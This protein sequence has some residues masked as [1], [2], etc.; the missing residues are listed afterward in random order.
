MKHCGTIPLETGRLIL[1]RFTPED[2]EAMFENWAGDPQ[3]TRYLTWSAHQSPKQTLSVLTRWLRQYRRADFYEWA[4][5]EKSS[6]ALIGSIGLA[7]VPG[8]R[9]SAEAGYS[10]GQRW[11]N[12]G[13]ATEALREVLDFAVHRVGYKRIIA[14]HAIENPASGRVMQK[15]GMS[16]CI[17]AI[18]SV[19]TE[20][21]IFDCYLYEF[22]S[23]ARHH[24]FW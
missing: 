14:K 1:R 7:G 16:L 13:Y 12:R 4:V 10:L 3:V 19:P 2:A 20:N 8:S 11:W 17:G 23:P 18:V 24:F 9:G 6:G 15:A 21:G 22:R 5:V